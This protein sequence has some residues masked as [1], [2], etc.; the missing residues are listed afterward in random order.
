MASAPISPERVPVVDAWH[1]ATIVKNGTSEFGVS[2]IA[3][4]LEAG[5]RMKALSRLATATLYEHGGAQF[6]CNVAEMDLSDFL[7]VR[8]RTNSYPAHVVSKRDHLQLYSLHSERP[9]K[10]SGTLQRQ[11]RLFLIDPIQ[12]GLMRSGIVS[13]QPEGL[14]ENSHIVGLAIVEHHNFATHRLL[15]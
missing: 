4:K 6:S 12:T 14:A 2:M 1:T 15:R 10:E 8:A 7:G 9:R 11:G 3:S 5:G 13:Q